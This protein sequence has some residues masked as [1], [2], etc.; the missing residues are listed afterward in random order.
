MTVAFA[1]KKKGADTCERRLHLTPTRTTGP[2]NSGCT[3]PAQGAADARECSAGGSERVDSSALRGVT[4]GHLGADERERARRR[5]AASGSG[6]GSLIRTRLSPIVPETPFISAA[7]VV[8]TA[9][10]ASITPASLRLLF[11]FDTWNMS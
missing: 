1:K 10:K 11:L 2:N 9:M 7:P 8:L 3:T 5:G 4:Q 6:G